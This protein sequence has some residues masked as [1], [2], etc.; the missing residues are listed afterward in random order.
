[1]SSSMG[2][3]SSASVLPRAEATLPV[4]SAASRHCCF[5]IGDECF[6]V[7]AEAVAEVLRDGRITRVPRAP[8]AVIGL[9]HLRG[10]IVPVIDMQ[11]YLG[12]SAAA[13]ARTHLVIRFQDDW[14]SLLVDEMLDVIEVDERHVEPCARPAGEGAED[15]VRG[16]FAAQTRLVHVLDPHRIIQALAR[17]RDQSLQRHGAFHGSV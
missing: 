2:T 15:A 14:Y 17:Q 16:T 5:L 4:T 10:R 8:E 11:R 13:A 3:V 6:A 9:V 1:M 12:L 7:P